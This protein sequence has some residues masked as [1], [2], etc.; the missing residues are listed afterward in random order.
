[1]LSESQIDNANREIEETFRNICEGSELGN[2][3][4]LGNGAHFLSKKF[5][6]SESFKY[7]FIK[8]E[9]KRSKILKGNKLVVKI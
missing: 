7:I 3:S 5:E 9:G 4:D 6:P 2:D 1:M 8:T